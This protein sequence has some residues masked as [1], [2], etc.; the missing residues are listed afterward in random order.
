MA[1]IYD[2]NGEVLSEKTEV[3]GRRK[4]HFEGLFQETDGPYQNTPWKEIPLKDN[5]E[6]AKEEVRSL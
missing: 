3:I 4:E 1:H 6:I 5:L 2:K